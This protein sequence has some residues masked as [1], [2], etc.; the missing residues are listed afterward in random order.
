MKLSMEH[1][2][3]VRRPRLGYEEM[4]QSVLRGG[5]RVEEVMNKG[6]GAMVTLIVM[7]LAA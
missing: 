3:R 7:N 2:V 1:Q 4:L 5:V 6:G